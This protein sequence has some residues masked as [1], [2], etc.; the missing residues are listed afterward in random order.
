MTTDQVTIVVAEDHPLYR[1]ALTALLGEQPGWSVVAEAEDGVGAVTAAHAAQPDVVVMDLRLP[2]LDGI[3][4]TRRIVA[5]SPHIAVLVLTMYDDDASVFAAMRAGARG[6]LLK[7]A[8]QADI[9]R[10]VAAVAGGEAIFGSPI[11]RRII[12]FFAAP[13]PAQVP[14][15]VFPE[16]TAREHEVLDLIA[17][18]RSN[19][20]VAAALVLSPRTVRNHVSNIFTKLHVADR[21]AAIVRAREAGLGLPGGAR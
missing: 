12:E 13:R 17:A 3:E 21:S 4:A 7:G 1:R 6:Y 20:D 16:L 11:A 18:G 19:A 8:D 2:G 9:V 10:A 15:I 5:A 14:E